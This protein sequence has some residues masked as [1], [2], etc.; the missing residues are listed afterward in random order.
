MQPIKVDW[1]TFDP[2]N[3]VAHPPKKNAKPNK[4]SDINYKVTLPNGTEKLLK[5]IVITTPPLRMPFGVQRNK[6]KADKEDYIMVLSLTG[7]TEDVKTK[8]DYFK[9]G[10]PVWIQS[11]DGERIHQESVVKTLKGEADDEVFQFATFLRTLDNANKQI[12]FNKSTEW[13]D[14][15]RS[16]DVIE[17]KYKPI[18]KSSKKPTE[19]SPTMNLT[20]SPSTQFFG[21]NQKLIAQPMAQY[22]SMRGNNVVCLIAADS[23]WFTDA[24]FGMKFKLLQVLQMPSSAKFTEL[25]I[26]VT[27]YQSY[28]DG[29][30]S[31]EE[32]EEDNSPKAIDGGFTMADTH[33]H[34]TGSQMEE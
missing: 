28:F 2:K 29:Y 18:L 6:F 11:A 30:A 10:T 24:G 8:K 13:F 21:P 23:F 4:Q 7:V 14:K 26:D 9:D 33:A 1:R 19:Y 25:A 31:Q 17:S 34:E 3:I 12:L 5:S 22:E 27:P 20:V 15:A 16:M 32:E